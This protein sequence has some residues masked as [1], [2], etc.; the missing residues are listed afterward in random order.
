MLARS[1]GGISGSTSESGFSRD[2]ESIDVGSEEEEEEDSKDGEEG[3][4]EVACAQRTVQPSSSIN[5]Q[6]ARPRMMKKVLI[7]PYSKGVI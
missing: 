6:V 2:S 3:P 4:C 1:S 7:R 5:Q